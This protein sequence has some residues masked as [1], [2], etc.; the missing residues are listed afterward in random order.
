MC[1]LTKKH[2]DRTLGSQSRALEVCGVVY[3]PNAPLPPMNHRGSAD[4]SPLGSNPMDN[5]EE[6]DSDSDEN[7]TDY[8]VKTETTDRFMS[9]AEGTPT[10]TTPPKPAA[11]TKQ[12]IMSIIDRTPETDS[13]RLAAFGDREALSALASVDA[14]GAGESAV[15]SKR[16]FEYSPDKENAEPDRAE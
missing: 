8:R 7:E 3:D 16:K 15:P 2:K 14:Q 10:E 6:M 9:D 12:S 4:G 1:H 5:D 13:V 11:S